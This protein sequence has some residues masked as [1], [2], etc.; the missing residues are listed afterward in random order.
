LAG[1]NLLY[2]QNTLSDKQAVKLNPGDSDFA[3]RV[4]QNSKDKL[5]EMGIKE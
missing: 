4:L 1:T 5:R 3:K 2:N